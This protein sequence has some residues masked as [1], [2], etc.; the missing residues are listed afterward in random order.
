MSSTWR[1]QQ[2][3]SWLNSDIWFGIFAKLR[4]C[5]N[6]LFKYAAAGFVLQILQQQRPDWFSAGPKQVKKDYTQIEGF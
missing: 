5:A 2:T 6:P 4:S 3:S 1:Q